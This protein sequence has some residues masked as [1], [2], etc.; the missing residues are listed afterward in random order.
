MS[1][2]LEFKLSIRR[3]ECIISKL[4]PKQVFI[5][6]LLKLNGAVF[7]TTGFTDQLSGEQFK[8][9]VAITIYWYI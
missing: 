7:T 3:C 1:L 8:G 6:A 5:K 4:T 9:C 2:V